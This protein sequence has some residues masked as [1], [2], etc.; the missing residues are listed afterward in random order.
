MATNP[1]PWSA[2]DPN[3]AYRGGSHTAN[4]TQLVPGAAGYNDNAAAPWH[5]EI[6]Q[7]NAFFGVPGAVGSI[8]DTW[9][10]GGAASSVGG[11]G[12]LG[13]Y[14]P[15]LL[16][17]QSQAMQDMMASWQQGFGAQQ[18]ESYD[19]TGVGGSFSQVQSPVYRP[20]GWGSAARNGAGSWGGP[21]SG[22]F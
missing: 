4:G 14:Q 5:R 6:A 18:G 3:Q 20:E 10:N 15:E 12:G 21:F 7:S 17:Q 19:P 9:S 11:L 2:Y 8:Q 22:K 1:T 16:Q 13:G